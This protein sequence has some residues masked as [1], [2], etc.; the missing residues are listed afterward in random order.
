MSRRCREL[1]N[2]S[3]GPACAQAKG[4]LDLLV[5]MAPPRVACRQGEGG[6]LLIGKSLRPAGRGRRA[7]GLGV[8]VL[9]VR[10]VPSTVPPGFVEAPAATG[11]NQPTTIEFS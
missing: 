10:V 5:T 1:S 6:F 2:R 7:P 8:E 9:E 3:R 4:A 11:L